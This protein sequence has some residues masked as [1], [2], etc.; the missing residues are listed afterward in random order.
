MARLHKW[1]NEFFVIG[2]ASA[3][4]Q[5][6]GN[7]ASTAQSFVDRL[8]D[9]KLFVVNNEAN[10]GGVCFRRTVLNAKWHL[11]S[12]F[13][14]P[15]Q[16]THFSSIQLSWKSKGRRSCLVRRRF[17]VV[18]WNLLVFL[19][20]RPSTLLKTLDLW[21]QKQMLAL[22]WSQPFKDNR[23]PLCAQ[24]TQRRRNKTL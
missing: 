14:Q 13:P 11:C 5:D 15:P 23:N 12:K 3:F 21:Q 18:A 20:Q 24:T 22:S 2:L 9:L 7:S 17:C 19:Q 1:S 4:I 16:I 10:G 6:S 8:A